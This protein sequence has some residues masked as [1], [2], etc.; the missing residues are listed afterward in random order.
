M[1]EDAAEEVEWM[2]AP[3]K[4]FEC[5]TLDGVVQAQ[6][7]AIDEVNSI[8]KVCVNFDKLCK[9]PFLVLLIIDFSW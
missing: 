3:R 1:A 7:N 2:A 8:L 9:D 4:T 6:I 5:L